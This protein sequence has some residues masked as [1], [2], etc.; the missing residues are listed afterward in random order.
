ME[1]CTIS[2]F[3]RQ[4]EDGVVESW[5]QSLI[6]QKHT[7]HL[8]LE[9]YFEPKSKSRIT[10]DL[11]PESLSHPDLES[12]SLSF[13]TLEAPHA[14]NNC[15]N[16]KR[17]KLHGI[18]AEIGVLNEVLVSCSSLEALTLRIIFYKRSGV[19]KIGNPKLKFL[20]LSCS[21]V[22]GVEVSTHSVD[23]LSIGSLGCEYENFI[24]A[25]PRL[26]QFRRN[27]WATGAY[28]P[29]TTYDISCSNQVYSLSFNCII[30]ILR[31]IHDVNT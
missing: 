7:K 10:L 17:L 15:W 24:I 9:N 20:Y 22:D 18:F 26:L 14:F 5:I 23:I 25:N 2:H 11:P 27:Y 28:F 1:R 30:F 16:L 6:H 12:L 4:C 13:Y 19:L 8:T 3:S 21:K 31:E 29:H